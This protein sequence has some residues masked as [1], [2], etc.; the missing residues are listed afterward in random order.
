MQKWLESYRQHLKK[1]NK[2]APNTR[3]F[4]IRDVAAYLSYLQSRGMIHIEET[5]KTDVKN[6]LEELEKKRRAPSTVARHLASLR[7]FYSF[8]WEQKIISDHPCHH[9][10]PPKRVK[11]EPD[12]LT[13]EEISRLL[14]VSNRETRSGQRNQAMLE[15]LYASGIR[16]TE[17]VSL[18]VSDF[19]RKL[20]ILKCTD[21]RGFERIIPL[22]RFAVASLD[23]Y[24]RTTRPRLVK[25]DQEPALFLNMRGTR[26]TRQGL[27]KI[28]KKCSEKCGL[29]NKVT[30]NTLRNSF[31]QH[32]LAGGAQLRVVQELMGHAHAATTEAY[33]SSAGERMKDTYL[34]YHPRA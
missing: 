19:N 24:L 9:I 14:R 32:M 21:S 27:W 8:L 4:Y 20:N 18:N 30:P 1:A 5:R 22:G 25:N 2:F 11:V 33:Y 31:A 34:K 16:V 10:S 23:D 15:L 26:M 28:L 17:L 29:E 6:Y 7:S 13:P 3:E 12:T